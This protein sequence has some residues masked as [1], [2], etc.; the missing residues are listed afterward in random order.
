MRKT[1]LAEKEIP[2]LYST[3]E[4]A[5]ILGVC[6]S[7]ARRMMRDGEIKTLKVGRRLRVKKEWLDKYLNQ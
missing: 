5:R 7:V 6:V 1:A 4:V 2:V 3:V